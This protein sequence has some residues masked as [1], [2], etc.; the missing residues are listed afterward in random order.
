MNNILF[1]P[2][3]ATQATNVVIVVLIV[4]VHVTIVEIHVPRVVGIGRI[5]CPLSEVCIIDK[6]SCTGC[7][8][9]DKGYGSL[10]KNTRGWGRRTVEY[11]HARDPQWEH[12]SGHKFQAEQ[13]LSHPSF[14]L[15]MP[16]TQVAA[17][18]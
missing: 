15:A 5:T 3:S 8:S 6:A 11:G 14:C 12:S 16:T 7:R 9:L 4:V 1:F 2:L 10:N 17:Y 18:S 13:L